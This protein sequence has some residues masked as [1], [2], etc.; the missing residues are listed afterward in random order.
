M[1][2]QLCTLAS[3]FLVAVLITPLFRQLS[4]KFGIIDAPDMHRKLHK[5]PVALCGGLVILATLMIVMGIATMLSPIATGTLPK[6]WLPIFSLLIASI[7][8]VALGMADDRFGLR[9][10]QK[11]LGQLL[12]CSGLVAAGYQI[13]HT[14][15]FGYEIQFGISSFVISVAWLLL[16]INSINLIDGADGLC[17]SVGWIACAGFA[18]MAATQGH[19]LQAAFAA[20][21]AGAL[22]GFLVYNFPPAK[23][24]LGDSGSMLV[25][26]I[27]GA[28]AIRTSLKSPTAVSMFGA[29][30]ILALPI[31]DSSM[32]IVRRKLT[33]RSIFTTDRGHLHHSLIIKG[34]SQSKLIL[35]IS[36]LSGALAIGAFSSMVLNSEL[37]ALISVLVVLGC[38]VSSR[39]FGHSELQL[40]ANRMTRMASS[41]VPFRSPSTSS[42]RNKVLVRLQGDRGWELIW[43]SL[44]EFADKHNLSR[45]CLDLNVPWLHEGYH[46]SWNRDK[47]P[48]ESQR[49]KMTMPIFSNAKPLGRIEIVGPVGESNSSTVLLSLAL[50]VENI[51]L[52]LQSIVEGAGAKTVL[53]EESAIDSKFIEIGATP[54]SSAS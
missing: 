52:E 41:F 5:E 10:R 24:F 33:G 1:V 14:E 42:Q 36:L 32:A 38:L 31:F 40:L 51:Q 39:L 27:L 48:D 12:I 9:G 28:L 47:L 44:V 18:A 26:L 6:N 22:L 34:I 54:L 35:I 4:L 50:L 25:G 45:V 2:V 37:F 46:A 53:L 49:W 3:S 19:W 30:A 13:N 21:V 23:V 17:C 20:S 29:V 11:L 16:T 43:E 7:A 8:I 15:V